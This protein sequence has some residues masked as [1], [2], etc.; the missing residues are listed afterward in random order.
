MIVKGGVS[1]MDA[2]TRI[3]VGGYSRMAKE[4]L[5]HRE[6]F[7]VKD[8]RSLD[9]FILGLCKAGHLPSFCTAGYR[10]GRT[11]AA[12]MP[13]AKHATVNK[14]CIANGLLTFREY[15]DDYASPGVRRIG[16][17]E[18]IPKYLAWVR[19]HVPD[20][21]GEVEARLARTENHERDLRF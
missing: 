11:G 21:Y 7:M 10:Q 8:S 5:E 17:T 2:G 13:L 6:Q 20:M 16:E 14:F 19:E 12:F 9:E 15:L 4:H 3:G 18:I 1:Q